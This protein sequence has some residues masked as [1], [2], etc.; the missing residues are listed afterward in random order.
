MATY[1]YRSEKVTIGGTLAIVSAAAWAAT[2]YVAHTNSVAMPGMADM[3]GMMPGTMA[4]GFSFSEMFAFVAAWAVMMVAMMLPSALPAVNGYLSLA[5]RR[6]PNQSRYLLSGL[7]SLGYCLAWATT[8]LVAY[9]VSVLLGLIEVRMPELAA[10]ATLFGG[11]FLAAIGVYQLTPMKESLLDHCRHPL[12][13]A[14]HHWYEGSGGA[15]LTGLAHGLYCIGSC[16]GLM[17]VLF[18]VGLMNLP[19]MLLLTLL[20]VVEKV[21]PIGPQVGKVAGLLL[22][23]LGTLMAAA[24]IG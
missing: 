14:M 8:G 7:L 2:I 5:E 10:N 15:L 4:I 11:P 17:A 12:R 19:A 18:V 16:W 23:V 24:A 6:L 13:F 21:A 9:A 20:I 1:V 3:A 22:I